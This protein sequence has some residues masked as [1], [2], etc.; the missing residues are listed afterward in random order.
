MSARERLLIFRG[1]GEQKLWE[2]PCA[3]GLQELTVSMAPQGRTERLLVPGADYSLMGSTL[4]CPVPDRA[5]LYVR[6]PFTGA[7][8]AAMIHVDPSRNAA[9]TETGSLQA[10]MAYASS[11]RDS[12]ADAYTEEQAADAPERRYNELSGRLRRELEEEYS[13]R[14]A[15][16]QHSLKSSLSDALDILRVA[17][18]QSRDEA[19]LINAPRAARGRFSLADGCASGVYLTI[20]N[21]YLVGTNTLSLYHNGSL[22]SPGIDYEE[23]G[24]PNSASST[25]RAL[26]PFPQG[27]VIEYVIAAI[28]SREA[29]LATLQ[30]AQASA[31]EAQIMLADATRERR[32]AESSLARSGEDSRAAQ[33]WANAARQEAERAWQGSLA[34]I[35]AASQISLFARRPGVS[36]VHDI[37]EIH[38]C[39]PGLFIINPHLTH[40]PTPFFGV[41]PVANTDEMQWDGVFFLGGV[42]YPPDPALPPARPPRPRPDP[43][44]TGGGADQW[45]PCDHSHLEAPPPQCCDNCWQ[46]APACPGMEPCSPPPKAEEEGE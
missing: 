6:L 18:T 29:A 13:E 23:A 45:I 46:F 4:F 19:A 28:P 8:E 39:S 44:P 43:A 21:P 35:E 22:L 36:A 9:S 12:S 38:A 5:M 42:C 2:L 14:L 37:S 25:V 34:A 32:E 17:S 15:A 27:S 10:P 3:P 16:L 1:D 7:G 11:S 33:A 26:R 20:T 41:W 24:Q 30:D 31:R 40:A